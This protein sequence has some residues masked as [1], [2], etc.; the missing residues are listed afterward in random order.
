MGPDR[1]GGRMGELSEG[2]SAREAAMSLRSLLNRLLPGKPAPAAGTWGAPRP[3]DRGQVGRPQIAMDDQGN[4]IAAWHHRGQ[5]HEGVYICRF[6]ADQR[7][8]DIVPRRLDSAR[9]QA[10]APEIAMNVRGEMAVVWQE[11]EGDQSRV[12]ARHMLGAAETWVP[13]PMTLQA[14]PGEVVSLHAAMD[15]AG[16]IH[17][18]WCAGTRGAY[19]VYA[20]GY[21]AEGGAWDPQPT[22]LGAPSA[23]AVYPQLAVNRAGQ[24]L[25]VWSEENDG[26]GNR[27]V[28]CHFEPAGRA[29]SDRPTEV[30]RGRATYLRMALDDRGAA[31]VLWVGAGEG[32]VQ[33]LHASHL[34]PRSLEW[35]PAPLL[36][37]G[38]AIHW[39]QVGLDAQG[40][41]H[42]LW[43]Q[44]A[45]GHE[46]LFA[47]RYTG[48]RWEEART[49]LA[50]D[51]GGNQ[52]HGLS[53]NAEGQALAIWSQQ[54]AGQASVCVRRFDGRTWSPRPLLLGAPGRKE[55]QTPG[56]VS[57]TSTL[58]R[59][60]DSPTK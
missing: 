51:L 57:T 40:R 19:R 56:A 35:T 52:A 55:I 27:L 44:E 48:G 31:V 4:A 33:N 46:K 10:Q 13:Y 8:W 26:A 28:A 18:V 2:P 30:A 50:E 36:A 43:R 41:A 59:M 15:P 34:D 39:P 9:T 60:Y 3:L 47:R 21:G 45:A 32:G 14:G 58:C 54:L 49:L 1:G 7:A 38:R 53:V 37:S 16:N 29:W 5:D 22:P 24:G 42:A 20:S 11:R 6:R 17:A 25:V 12:C 23:R